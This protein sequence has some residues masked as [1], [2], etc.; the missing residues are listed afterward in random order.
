[1]PSP[2]ERKREPLPR[3]SARPAAAPAPVPPPVTPMLPEPLA[4]RPV[5]ST[6]MPHIPPTPRVP[7]RMEPE[8]VA[9]PPPAPAPVPAPVSAPTAVPRPPRRPS[10]PGR[11]RLWLLAGGGVAVLLALVVAGGLALRSRHT[12][13]PPRPTPVVKKLPPPLPVAVPQPAPPPPVN[14]Q[15]ALAEGQLV[16]GDLAG[17]KKTLEAIPEDQKARFTAEESDRFQKV[18]AT[19]APFDTEQ[20]VG[21]LTQA[22][23]TGD[24]RSLKT[25]LAALTPDQ[26]AALSPEVKKDLARARKVL[27]ADG[28]LT[29]AERAQEPLDIL[30]QAGLLLAELPR[31]SHALQARERAAA[32]I[33]ADAD[34]KIEDGSYDAALA[35]LQ[36]LHDLWPERRGLSDRMGKIQG[37]RK[38]DQALED[39]L[40]LAAQAEKQGK[41]ADGL[42]A[43]KGVEPN[44]RYADRFR[45]A[46]ERLEAQQLAALD[47]KPPEIACPKSLK[48]LKYA[49]GTAITI[50]L[51]ITDDL[52]VKSVE[53]WAR[54]KDGTFVRLP[55]RQVSGGNYELEIQ[56]A[57][58]DN[59]EVEFYVTA[60]DRSGHEGHFGTAQDPKQIKRR[61]WPF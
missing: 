19:L 16:A 5:V 28:R 26:E 35:R 25:Q 23:A 42:A 54:P 60:T 9:P 17:A 45:Q 31:S 6:P 21:H 14:P 56:P 44:R 51:R 53:A 49:K 39:R 3:L 43:L 4:T 48:D 22:L 18:L 15:I 50:P 36:Q 1:P 27:E 8:P 32:E 13:P 52:E 47:R 46:R 40:A 29:R 2:V 10:P 41:P 55:V 33:E 11:Q 61:L 20:R 34:K 37:D 58:H 30:R 24:L 38:A 57:L 7:P 59:K 12:P